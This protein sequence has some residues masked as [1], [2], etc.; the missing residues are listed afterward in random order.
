MRQAVSAVP[1]NSAQ[2]S[3]PARPASVTHRGGATLLSIPLG[4][5][6]TMLV[7]DHLDLIPH[8]HA[9]GRTLFFFFFSKAHKPISISWVGAVYLI[10]V[11]GD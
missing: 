8:P 10:I 4:W 7:C 9:N 5:A 11:V 2:G 6:Q 1:R 3:G